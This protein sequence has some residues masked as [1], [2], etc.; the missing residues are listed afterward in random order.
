MENN[1]HS[2]VI[3]VK[4]IELC[5]AFYRDVL[6]LGAPAMDSNFWV[7]FKL[8]DSVSL[9]LEKIG[10]MDLPKDSLNRVSWILKTESTEFIIEKL[11]QY[12]YNPLAEQEYRVGFK[13]TKFN[14]PEGNAF[15]VC[16]SSSL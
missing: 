13:M 14:D 15:Y 3:K 8:S 11:R 6:E 7:E 16:P 1:L 9:L 4:N 12:G 10:D 2:I 5:R